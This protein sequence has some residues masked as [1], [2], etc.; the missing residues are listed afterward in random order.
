MIRATILLAGL[1][2]LVAGC[3]VNKDYV[4]QQIAASE[5]RTGAKVSTVEGKIARFVVK[6]FLQCSNG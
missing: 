6:V 4:E 2:L 5:A 1:L 3:G